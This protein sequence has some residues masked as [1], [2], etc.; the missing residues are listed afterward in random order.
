MSVF[1]Q[2]AVVQAQQCAAGSNMLRSSASCACPGNIQ[3]GYWAHTELSPA[4]KWARA[5]SDIPHDSCYI[6]IN[7]LSQRQTRDVTTIFQPGLHHGQGP[8]EWS[9]M[10]HMDSRAKFELSGHQAG[11][12]A[13]CDFSL[14]IRTHNVPHMFGV[15]VPYELVL[16]V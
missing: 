6:F 9:T 15:R 7:E 8:L 1:D 10:C 12:G 4:G 13:R 3:A 16:S 11:A 14:N 5:R 2:V